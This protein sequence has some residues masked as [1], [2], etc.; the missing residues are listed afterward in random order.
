MCLMDVRLLDWGESNKTFSKGKVVFSAYNFLICFKGLSRD[1]VCLKSVFRIL[2]TLRAWE[3]R[4][5]K[6]RKMKA[7]KEHQESLWIS[8]EVIPW[9]YI[10]PFYVGSFH[11]HPN[12]IQL[13]K[14]DF[15]KW[16][17]WNLMTKK[18]EF[19]VGWIAIYL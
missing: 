19:L 4:E 17:T 9:R 14:L 11:P 15:I 7:K 10:K 16:W 6:R 1:N 8:S 2:N 3:K 5:E 13:S 12:L 18:Y